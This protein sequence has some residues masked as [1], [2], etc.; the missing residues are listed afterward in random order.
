MKVKSSK[1]VYECP[2]LRVEERQVILP[3]GV[4]QIHWV[5]VRQPNVTVVAITKDNKI[6]LI[7]EIRG[8]DDKETLE[9]PGGKLDSYNPTREEA[10][11]VALSELE[12]ETGYQAK[13]IRL[14]EI[15][16]RTSNWRERQ[17][18][19]FVAWDLKHVGQKLEK[20]ETIKVKLVSVKEAEEIVK[21]RRMTF[22]D[23]NDALEKGLGFF[24][25]SGLI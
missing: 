5:V 20:G 7:S 22:E 4:E 21:E 17:Y 12:S 8:K 19:H 14:L 16:E 1:V 18:Y 3:D 6:V 13:N 24:E 25:E 11:K 2:I 9:L 15:W 23:E 10:K